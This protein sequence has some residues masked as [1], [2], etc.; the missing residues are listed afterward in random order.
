M[1]I[2]LSITV[3]GCSN[4]NNKQTETQ[5]EYKQYMT[6]GKSRVIDEEYDK[7]KEFFKLALENK[8][9]DKEATNL[10]KQI[11]LFEEVIDLNEGEHG[12]YFSAIEKLIELDKIDTNTDVVKSKAMDYRKS[13]IDNI[14][15]TIDYE[16]ELINNGEYE[17][18]KNDLED[19]IKECKKYDILKDQLNKCNKLL[20]ICEDNIDKTEVK[21]NDATNNNTNTD[22]NSGKLWCQRGSHYV[23]KKNYNEYDNSCNGCFISRLLSSTS[24]NT[25]CP[26][27][28]SSCTVHQYLGTCSNCGKQVL[29]PIKK[30]R[31]DGT[32]IREDGSID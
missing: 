8:K 14:D 9:N 18:A 31:E 5:T 29:S 32:V 30:I 24:M 15:S 22:N 21:K 7:A 20:K 10:I 13:V 3:V 6:D 4:N 11:D 16:E 23:D 2:I 19:T 17:K 26:Y 28:G 25:D 27:C 12:A 1:T